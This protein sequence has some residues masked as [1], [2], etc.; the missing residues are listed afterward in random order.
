MSGTTLTP[1][2]VCK[3]YLNRL[4]KDPDGETEAQTGAW[5]SFPASRGDECCPEASP[6]PS[7]GACRVQSSSECPKEAGGRVVT[8]CS[9]VT[10]EGQCGQA[11]PVEELLTGSPT[12]QLDGGTFFR[13]FRRG[14]LSGSHFFPLCSWPLS[15]D[16]FLWVSILFKNH[17]VPGTAGASSR[18][19]REAGW[20]LPSLLRAGICNRAHIS[21][22]ETRRCRTG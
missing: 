20:W 19:P 16:P 10:R 6:G 1:S 9:V 15:C 3:L 14:K 21:C 5:S 18:R 12:Q 4:P 13:P 7:L 22:I 2:Q 11:Q 8:G 17:R